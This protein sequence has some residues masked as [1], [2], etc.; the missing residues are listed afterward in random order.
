MQRHILNLGRSG[1]IFKNV[2]RMMHHNYDYPTRQI[3]MKAI[4]ILYVHI[5]YKGKVSNQQVHDVLLVIHS[6]V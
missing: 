1:E 6:H 5:F 4:Q 3:D 2:W